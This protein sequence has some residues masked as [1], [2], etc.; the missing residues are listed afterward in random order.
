MLL[1]IFQLL[2]NGLAHD[3]IPMTANS[4]RTHVQAQSSRLNSWGQMKNIL[5]MNKKTTVGTDD[6]ITIIERICRCR[7]YD[8]SCIRLRDDAS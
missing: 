2:P 1:N 4:I 7:R 6:T 3:Y 8:A 5:T